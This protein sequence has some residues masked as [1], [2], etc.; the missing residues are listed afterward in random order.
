MEL[1]LDV[2]MDE[3]SATF[4]RQ[5]GVT[6][7]VARVPLTPSGVVT[8]DE[9]RRY[10]EFLSAHGLKWEVTH[11]P[12]PYYWKAMLGVDGRD[13]QIEKYC[14]SISVLAEVGVEVTNFVWALV[15]YL[16]SEYTPTG[17]GG[18][19]YPRFD[20]EVATRL[21][22]S[23][24]DWW[25][26][27]SG[28]YP[29]I[30]NRRIE[31]EEVWDNLS[32]FLERV[33]PVAEQ[34]GMKLSVHPDDPPIGEFLGV[35]RVLSSPDALQRFL[36]LVPSPNI[37]LLFC[38]GTVATMAGVDPIEQIFRF[39]RQGR[40]FHVH[41]RNPKG[42]GDYF[43]EVLPDEGDTD[44]AAGIRAYRD[45]G[46]DRLVLIDHAPA[47]IGADGARR[48]F[49]FQ[50]GHAKGLVAAMSSPGSDGRPSRSW[51]PVTEDTA[52]GEV[53]AAAGAA[54]PA[55]VAKLA[56]SLDWWSDE[57]LILARQLGV[58][59][60]VGSVAR[61]SPDS[62][63]GGA[64]RTRVAGLAPA[65]AEG[66]PRAILHRIASVPD[67][68]A[69][70]G[71]L[72][73]IVRW[74]GEAGIPVLSIEGDGRPQYTERILEALVPVA[75]ECHVAL[76]VPP[77]VPPPP[78][79]T[80]TVVGADLRLDELVAADGRKALDAIAGLVESNR[81]LLVR[82][83]HLRWDRE[84][85]FEEIVLRALEVLL[86]VDV[87]VLPGATPQLIDDTQWGHT[88]HALSAGFLRAILQAL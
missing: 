66:V 45:I 73:D 32:Y 55:P 38:Q 51:R 16:R 59:H 60:I 76:A 3:A 88:S 50:L 11:L 52:A 4:A 80:P 33:L 9:A 43:E 13:E 21:G 18:T 20:R 79:S 84:T 57:N 61:W 83:G 53:P 49:A 65:A 39:G 5:V 81:V 71:Q 7:V 69:A 47:M 64:H 14:R 87:P 75:E 54:A 6:R 46:Y 17:R 85:P 34:V 74:V 12:Y 41:I 15:G 27:F 67:D 36:E 70:I 68:A 77:S 86:A 37:G 29:R 23:A 63:A 82:V 44:M 72:Q 58:T 31:A 62:L 1:S 40:I 2:K 78:R 25:G 28:D 56:L 26:R 48:S 8:R 19:R 35:A 22:P 30:P 42:E 24:L 10:L